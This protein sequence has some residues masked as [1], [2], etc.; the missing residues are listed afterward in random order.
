MHSPYEET[1]WFQDH[2]LNNAL[3]SF[4][5][6]PKILVLERNFEMVPLRV[7]NVFYKNIVYKNTRL[8]YAKSFKI[9]LKTF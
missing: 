4:I 8:K 5:I 7:T 3:Y 9:M 1:N 2:R 6:V